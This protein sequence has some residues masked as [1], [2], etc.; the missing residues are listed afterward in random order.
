MNSRTLLNIVG[1][2]ADYE[3]EVAGDEI[4]GL[5]VRMRMHGPYGAFFESELN[6]H[7]GTVMDKHPPCDSGGWADGRDRLFSGDHFS[8]RLARFAMQRSFGYNH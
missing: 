1:L 6:G 3:T 5:F 4:A 8:L 7:E 2:A